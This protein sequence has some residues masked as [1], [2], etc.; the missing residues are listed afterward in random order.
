MKAIL[1]VSEE[2]KKGR[3]YLIFGKEQDRN[4]AIVSES[5]K[6]EVLKQQ[7]K[8]KCPIVPVALLDSL[9]KPFDTNTIT[10]AISCKVHFLKT[11]RIR[12]L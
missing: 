7:Q 12:G 6:E 11:S 4:K 9:F 3:N 5:L 10:L 8:A 2:S 1:D